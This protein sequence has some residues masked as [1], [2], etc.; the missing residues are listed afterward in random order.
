MQGIQFGWIKSTREL[1]ANAMTRGK[2][3]PARP[4]LVL[5]ISILAYLQAVEGHYEA[6]WALANVRSS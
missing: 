2:Q 4:S 5:C 1:W 3:R 6:A